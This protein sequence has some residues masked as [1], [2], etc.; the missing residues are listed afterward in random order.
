MT[1]HFDGPKEDDEEARVSRLTGQLRDVYEALLDGERL[2]LGGLE[3][4][5]GHPQASISAQL[6]NLRKAR[7][8]GFTINKKNIDGGL[9]VYW[10]E[11]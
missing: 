9:Y 7:F 2:T 10:L 3:R 5:T 8:G 6:R 4:K 1:P 11:D